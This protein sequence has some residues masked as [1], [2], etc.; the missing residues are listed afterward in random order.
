MIPWYWWRYSPRTMTGESGWSLD[1]A[2]L[3]F[4][5]GQRDR[6]GIEENRPF[7][8]NGDGLVLGAHIRRGASLGRLTLI[9]CA[10]A[11]VMNDEDQQQHEVR[12]TIGVTLMSAIASPSESAFM[13]I[14]SGLES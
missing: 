11:V 8:V 5:F 10:P 12:S 6:Q 13:A 7:V 1:L 2:E 4:Q 14:Q 3:L 9:A